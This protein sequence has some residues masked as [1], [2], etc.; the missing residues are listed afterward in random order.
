MHKDGEHSVTKQVTTRING[1]KKITRIAD[2]KTR[3]NVATG[4]VQSKLQYLM[5]LWIGAPE[6]LIKALQVQQLNAARTVCGYGSYFWSTSKLL[7]KCKWL[8]VKKQM[9]ASTLIVAHGIVMSGVP[10]NINASFSLQHPYR[11]R[12]ASTGRIRFT[13]KSV[14]EKTFRF[15]ARKYYNLIP[16]ELREKGQLQFKRLIKKWVRDNIPIR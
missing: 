10:L 9:V 12:Q 16:S 4:I 5:P 14:S 7:E 15:Q 11:T 13:E 6:Y 8:S 1:L 3:L 2:F